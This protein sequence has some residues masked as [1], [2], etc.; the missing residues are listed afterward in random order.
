MMKKG[1]WIATCNSLAK[2]SGI[3]AYANTGT[4]T[5]WTH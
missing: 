1:L 5:F 3:W 2:F 4:K